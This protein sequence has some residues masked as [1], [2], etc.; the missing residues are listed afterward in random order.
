MDVAGDDPRLP[1]RLARL[2][3]ASGR[4]DAAAATLADFIKANPLSQ[5]AARIKAG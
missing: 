1:A 2:M 4:Q 5:R 3:K